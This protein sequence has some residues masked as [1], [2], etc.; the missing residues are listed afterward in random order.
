MVSLK[1]LDFS[2]ISIKKNNI[3]A[4][5]ISKTDAKLK[6]KTSNF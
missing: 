5:I 4:L 1:N 2:A 6:A 3:L